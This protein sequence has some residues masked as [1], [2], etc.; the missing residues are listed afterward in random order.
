MKTILRIHSLLLIGIIVLLP[1]CTTIVNWG[2]KNLYQGIDF[3]QDYSIPRSFVRS[4]KAYDQFST[5]A[6]F[7]VLWLSEEVRNAYVA[8]FVRASGKREEQKNQL[9][10]LQKDELKH[11]ITFYVVTPQDT[12]LNIENSPWHI[13]LSVDELTFDPIEIKEIELNS[14]Y[15][16][17]FGKLYNRFKI[18]Y[19]IKFEARDL[20]D[21][22]LIISTTQ[23]IE[24]HFKKLH[25]EILLRWDLLKVGRSSYEDFASE[26]KINSESRNEHARLRKTNKKVLL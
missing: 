25:K 8:T 17:F 13:F 9:L 20:Y 4:I 14:I 16:S 12:I 10:K 5:F 3:Y 19:Q 15:K 26:E 24:L 6:H 23:A 2:K 1:G 21:N 18:V 7:D 11:F 22:P